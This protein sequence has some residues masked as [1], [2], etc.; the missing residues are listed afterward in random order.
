MCIIQHTNLQGLLFIYL[1]IY[2]NV[3]ASQISK[4]YIDFRFVLDFLS[5]I[6]SNSINKMFLIESHTGSNVGIFLLFQNFFLDFV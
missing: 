4:F 5:V 3:F 1:F 2:F 6:T